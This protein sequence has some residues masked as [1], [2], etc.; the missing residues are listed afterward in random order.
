MSVY[1]C[2]FE[3]DGDTFSIDVEADSEEAAIIIAD[4]NGY[5]L[6]GEKIDEQTIGN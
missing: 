1:I 4:I 3:H 2:Y 5:E 6:M